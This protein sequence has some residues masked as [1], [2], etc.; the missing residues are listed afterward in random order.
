MIEN[1][2]IYYHKIYV[3]LLYWV[4]EPTQSNSAL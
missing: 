4:T 3:I 2:K 1:K